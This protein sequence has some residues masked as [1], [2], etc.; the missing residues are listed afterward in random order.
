MSEAHAS[1]S[2]WEV[3]LHFLHLC[4][5]GHTDDFAHGSQHYRFHLSQWNSK[6]HPHGVAQQV[7][8]AVLQAIMQYVPFRLW[9]ER[10]SYKRLNLLA[11]AVASSLNVI[12]DSVIISERGPA[13]HHPLHGSC[14]TK[15]CGNKFCVA[16]IHAKNEGLA[17]LAR[18]P[19]HDVPCS[20]DDCNITRLQIYVV[21][22]RC[23]CCF[24]SA[25]LSFMEG[26]LVCI[27]QR[28]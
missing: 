21:V 8:L 17:A 22:A 11:A 4:E 20:C 6:I 12:R 25:L 14:R 27:C 2:V 18:V 24:C 9:V 5:L 16:L 7:S 26:G 13:R 28:K 3:D 19:V 23:H 1:V 10:Q 15:L